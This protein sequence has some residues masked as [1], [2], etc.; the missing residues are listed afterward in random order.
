MERAFNTI[1]ISRE[2]NEL[3]VDP[4]SS[5]VLGEG[6]ARVGGALSASCGSTWPFRRSMIRFKRRID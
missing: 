4:A 1:G 5:A 2:D 3:A 6:V